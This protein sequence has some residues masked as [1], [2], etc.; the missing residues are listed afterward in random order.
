MGKLTCL[1]DSY[2]ACLIYMDIIS[3]VVCFAL[4]RKDNK[5]IKSLVKVNKILVI[6]ECM[7]SYT[8]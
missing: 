3:V 2:S 6:S 4:F 7:E 1:K 8:L 5:Y